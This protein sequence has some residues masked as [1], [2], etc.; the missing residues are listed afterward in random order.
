[1]QRR[2]LP[3]GRLL[4]LSFFFAGCVSAELSLFIEGEEQLKNAQY[5]EAYETFTRYL[6]LYRATVPVYYD[7]AQAAKALGRTSDA[8][9]DLARVIKENPGDADAR[10]IRYRLLSDH[11]KVLQNAYAT[12]DPV[13]RPMVQGLLTTET[14]LML[15]DLAKLLGSDRFDIEARSER[16]SLLWSLGALPEARADLD[17]ILLQSPD[18]VWALNAR[19]MLLHRLGEYAAAVADYDDALDECDSCTYIVYN[20][21]LSLMAGGRL[22]EAAKAFRAFLAAD[23][24]DG[25]AWLMLAQ[26]NIDL[27]RS[28]EACAALRK[29]MDLG[30]PEARER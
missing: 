18:D 22:H 21:A 4:L 19:G 2:G 11:Q 13:L 30:Q 1:M 23:S 3:R 28:D 8:L 29:S 9:Q 25:E 24:L 26:C 6:S 20:R 27:G 17:T 7:R 15:D 14:L 16:A 12:T 10:W 5:A